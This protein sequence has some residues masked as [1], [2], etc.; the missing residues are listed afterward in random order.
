M[1]GAAG[2]VCVEITS[3][4]DT[5]TDSLDASERRAIEQMRDG[6]RSRSRQAKPHE[7]YSDSHASPSSFLDRVRTA[8]VYRIPSPVSLRLCTVCAFLIQ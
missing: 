2:R 1:V 8:P 6:E 7:V 4:E 5:R 3:K